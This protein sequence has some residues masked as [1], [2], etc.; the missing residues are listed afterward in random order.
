MSKP[1]AVYIVAGLGLMVS[2]HNA[3]AVAQ[4]DTSQTTLV[5]ER[6]ADTGLSD[7]LKQ[8]RETL[9]QRAGAPLKGHAWWLWGLSTFDYD[10][11]GDLDMIVCI[12]G[13]TNGLIIRNDL[14]ETGRLTFRDV[15]AELGVDGVVPSTDNYPLVWDFDGDGD[16]DI[17]G[18][19]DDRATPCLINQNGKRFDKAAYSLHPINYPDKIADLD[20]DGDIDIEQTRR[21]RTIRYT[22]DAASAT[23]KKSQTDALPPIEMPAAVSQRITALRASRHN[24]FMRLTYLRADLNGDGREDVVL[25]AFAGYS[26]D[27]LGWYFVAQQDGRYTDAT[28]LMGLPREGAPVVARDFDGDGSTDV[29]IA[30]GDSAGLYLND[31]RGRFKL[32]AGPLTDFVKQRCPYLHVAH[33]ADLDNDGDQDVAVSNRRY[34][35]QQVFENR[36]GG[37]YVLALTSRGWDADPLVLRDM[38]H[39][40]RIDVVIGGAGEK[41]TIGVFL[42]KSP[43]TGAFCRLRVRMDKPNVYAVGTRVEVFKAGELGDADGRP[44]LVEETKPDGTPVHIGLGKAKRFDLRLTFPGRNPMVF[45]NIFA[46][47]DLAVTPKGIER[48]P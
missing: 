25:R 36:G 27:R 48:A 3:D 21:G 6:A 14:R 35:R 18:L 42:N 8:R 19:L 26:G 41:E 7:I 39:D 29:L 43:N 40:G 34:G 12:H 44:F 13:S 16:L 32:K 2:L 1:L 23:F 22:Y 20:G 9:E 15:T 24:R 37:R 33:F 17:A 28:E 31:G 47:N 30:S 10:R 4:T 11:D 5:F 38:D 45:K 46:E